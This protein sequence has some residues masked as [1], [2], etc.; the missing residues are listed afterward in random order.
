MSWEQKKQR[1]RLRNYR[2][3]GRLP[4]RAKKTI[5]K[6]RYSTHGHRGNK[7]HDDIIEAI[8]RATQKVAEKQNQKDWQNKEN[9]EGQKE[10]VGTTRRMEFVELNKLIKRS[11]RE[12]TR[13][14]HDKWGNWKKTKHENTET[15]SGLE[16]NLLRTGHNNAG[17]SNNFWAS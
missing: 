10:I 14:K 4:G 3:Q 2:R 15:E 6:W 7:W 9:I 1:W 12:S 8:N 5:A 17:K 13:N 11:I 16:Y